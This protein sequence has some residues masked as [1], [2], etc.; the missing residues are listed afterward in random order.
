MIGSED[1]AANHDVLQI[2]EVL[3]ITRLFTLAMMLLVLSIMF[4]GQN[5]LLCRCWMTVL[6][7]ID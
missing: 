5:V 1:L 4:M 7:M 3:V 2:V 6:E